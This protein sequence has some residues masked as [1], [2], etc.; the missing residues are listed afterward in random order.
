MGQNE[1]RTDNPEEEDNF[2]DIENSIVFEDAPK[3]ILFPEFTSN[4]QNNCK[5]IA[6]SIVVKSLKM[7]AGFAAHDRS[8]WRQTKAL[9]GLQSIYSIRE[10]INHRLMILWEKD[11]RLEV[12]DLIPREQ[13]EKW[14][15]GFRR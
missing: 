14:I 2:D 12:L 10:G 15:K 3:K 6:A 4:Y 11:I 8:V 7:A 13:L 9:S 1:N 5:T